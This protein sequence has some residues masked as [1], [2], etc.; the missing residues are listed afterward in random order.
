MDPKELEYF[1]I[2]LRVRHFDNHEELADMV[3][4]HVLPQYRK[5]KW[6][7]QAQTAYDYLTGKKH[8]NQ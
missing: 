8:D 7:T 1:A 6:L 3:P 5:D 2:H 4:W